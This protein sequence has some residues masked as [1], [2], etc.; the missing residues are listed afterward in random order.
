M[1]GRRLDGGNRRFRQITDIAI[2]T[3]FDPG[4]AI[5]PVKH[6]NL[7]AQQHLRID[8]AGKIRARAQAITGTAMRAGV[9]LT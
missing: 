3:G 2:Q 8:S 7:F 4:P 9:P 1:R 6:R 5:G